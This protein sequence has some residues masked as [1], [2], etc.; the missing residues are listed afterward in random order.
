MPR[1]GTETRE[2]ILDTAQRL[3]IE[4]GY[5]ATPLEQLIAEAST[6]KGAFFHHFAS[7]A[8]LARALVTRYVHADLAQLDAGL[9]AV[10]DVEDPK[11]RVLAFLRFYEDGADELMSAQSGCLYATVLAE[12]DL[13]RG[14]VNDLIGEAT[15]AWRRA[16]VELL[17]P[18]VP[19]G[20]GAARID[21]DALA[22][23]LYVTFEGAFLLSRTIDD[24]SAMR[25]QLKILGALVAALL[26]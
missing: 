3:M 16:I 24:P 12:Q 7:K 20:R 18:A 19:R 23:H 17:R 14:E 2:R 22:D 15:L 26:A 11:A 21:L 25:A 1:D 4:Q 6:S 8:D 9:A 5:S 13:L 10:A